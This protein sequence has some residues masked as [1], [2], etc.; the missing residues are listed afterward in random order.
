VS[1]NAAADRLVGLSSAEVLGERC[2]EVLKSRDLN[3]CAVCREGCP[4]HRAAASG[5]AV[6][7]RD[8]IIRTRP[9]GPVRVRSTTVVL[10]SGWLAHL[11]IDPCSGPAAT[12]R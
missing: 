8:V 12:E 2:F 4:A 11:L 9:R 7:T 1:W 5:E 3:G 10:P 6:A